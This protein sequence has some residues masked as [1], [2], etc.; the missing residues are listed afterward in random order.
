M[1]V[2]Q[3]KINPKELYNLNPEKFLKLLEYLLEIKITSLVLNGDHFEYKVKVDK[4]LSDALAGRG[5]KEDGPFKLEYAEYSDDCNNILDHY[6]L[7]IPFWLDKQGLTIEPTRIS[8]TCFQYEI[9]V[10]PNE[11]EEEFKRSIGFKDRETMLADAIPKAFKL[12]S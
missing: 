9:S 7:K 5:P 11:K 2:N 4:Y 6:V 8:E 3:I 12:L 1:E 10:W